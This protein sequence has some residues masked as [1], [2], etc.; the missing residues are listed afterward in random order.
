MIDKNMTN[1]KRQCQNCKTDFVIEPEDFKFYEKIKV[2]PPTFCPQCRF[3]RRLM[4]FNQKSLYKRKCDLCGRDIISTHSSDKP[5]TVYCPPC[6]WSDKWNG[7]EYASEYDSS[8][9][10]LEQVKDL[11]KK[12]P[13][14]A[15]NV[16]YA[17]NI[18]C[19]T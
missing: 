8:R 14:L 4:F 5:F 6:W 18:N 15:L 19:D 7:D 9:P 10:F 17:T 11:A 16:D 3:Q 13:H 1:E 12:T 2:P